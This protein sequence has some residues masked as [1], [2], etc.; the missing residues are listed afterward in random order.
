[1][2][3]NIVKNIQESQEIQESQKKI[4]YESPILQPNDYYIDY[5]NK[6]IKYTSNDNNFYD[7][8]WYDFI[9]TEYICYTCKS[10]RLMCYGCNYSVID[11]YKCVKNKLGVYNKYNLLYCSQCI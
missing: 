2:N 8:F 4:I 1:M 3:N 6:K 11:C 5:E 7:I 10:L 9:E